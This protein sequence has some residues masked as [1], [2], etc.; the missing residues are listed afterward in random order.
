MVTRVHRAGCPGYEIGLL[1]AEL[2]TRFGTST[3]NK[4]S[5]TCT[6][7]RGYT[8]AQATLLEVLPHPHLD[9]IRE[10]HGL[11][12]QVSGNWWGSSFVLLIK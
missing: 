11:F 5:E 1:R 9:E 12:C 4:R 3:V 10:Q 8:G 6:T 7:K 2:D